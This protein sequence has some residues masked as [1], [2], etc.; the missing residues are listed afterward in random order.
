MDTAIIDMLELIKK[1]DVEEELQ[2]AL[3]DNQQDYTNRQRKQILKGERSDGKP[4]FRVSTGSDEYSKQYAKKKGKTKPI[5][6]H[7]TGD[8]QFEIF[9]DVRDTELFIDSADSKSGMLQK[10]Y[11]EEIFG[12]QDE[13]SSEFGETTA[14]VLLQRVEKKL[15]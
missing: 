12:L 3:I 4:I 7:D 10:D 11:G 15:S 2:Q 8:F 1:I 9:M 6:L 5:D 14:E 13:G